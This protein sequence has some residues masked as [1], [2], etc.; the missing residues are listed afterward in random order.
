[1]RMRAKTALYLVGI[2]VVC[3]SS[4]AA[5]SLRVDWQQPADEID[6][7]TI[8]VQNGTVTL[9]AE[10]YGTI[11][12]VEIDRR[13]SDDQ[14]DDRD[15]FRTQSLDNVT[16]HVGS[17]DNTT[18]DI[19][20]L[21]ANGSAD[22]TTMYVEV[23][24]EQK[25]TAELT[26]TRVSNE[27][28]RVAGVIRDNAQPHLLRIKTPSTTK[29]INLRT[30]DAERQTLGGFDIRRESAEIETTVSVPASQQNLS[31]ELED[32]ADNVRELQL[33]IGGETPTPTPTATPTP[34]ETQTPTPAEGTTK[35]PT[36]TTT[37]TQTPFTTNGTDVPTPAADAS[38]LNPVVA[39]LGAVLVLV[40]VVVFLR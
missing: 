12:Y 29:V 7:E 28:V 27:T 5:Q 17:L 36:P 40:V 14:T 32:R 8:T 39:G 24:D 9:D 25:P 19:R 26:A 20:V 23:N 2:L 3:S 16:V 15:V 30:L 18:I 6:G 13:Y 1:M 22:T 4:G 31:I 10:V 38:G 33:P 11:D 35:D 37:T 34:T 21:G